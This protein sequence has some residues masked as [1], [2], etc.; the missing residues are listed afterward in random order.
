MVAMKL[1]RSPSLTRSSGASQW[2]MSAMPMALSHFSIRAAF[3]AS[4]RP[5]FSGPTAWQAVSLD[6]MVST[7]PDRPSR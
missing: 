5:P 7:L 4:P 1:G 3:F 2:T 6:W